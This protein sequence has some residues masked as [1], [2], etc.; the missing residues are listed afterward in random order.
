MIDRKAANKRT[1]KILFIT[2]YR[3]TAIVHTLEHEPRAEVWIIL[4]RFIVWQG[5]P[6]CRNPAASG[7]ECLNIAESISE[8]IPSY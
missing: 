3:L 4:G 1:G 7:N 8:R 2:D 5:D 6:G